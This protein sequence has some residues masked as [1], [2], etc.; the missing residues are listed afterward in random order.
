MIVTSALDVVVLAAARTPVTGRSRAQ[1]HRTAYQLAADVIAPLAVDARAHLG[2]EPTGV[3]LG[4]CIGPGGNIARVAALGAGLDQRVTGITVDAQC[5]SGLVAIIQAAGQSQLVGA[6]LIAGGTESPSTAPIRTFR[7][8]SYDQ[9]PFTPSGWPDPSMTE[10]ADDLATARGISR[11]RQEDAALRSHA[12]SLRHAALAT[13]EIAETHDGLSLGR[14]DGPR[15]LDSTR[16]ARFSPVRDSPRAT[17][18]PTTAA[19]IADGAAAVLLAPMGGGLHEVAGGAPTSN[20][21]ILPACRI[22]A[23]A[24]VGADPQQPGIVAANAISACLAAAG[25]RLQQLSAV[26]I[27]EAYAAQLLAVVDEL[28]LTT[29]G[30]TETGAPPQLDPRVNA[31]G[32]ALAL[33][34]PWG[35]S[36]A[37][38]LGRLVRRLAAAEPGALG[39]AACAIAGGMGSAVIVE[40]LEDPRGD[41]G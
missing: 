17:V 14:D 40:R 21:T 25:V 26:E 20:R 39:V 31:A 12:L 16:A 9:A 18:T 15:R 11:A 24:L 33:G 1:S 36:G 35:A 7:G 41:Q 5:G 2:V 37:I 3:V 30:T 22:R 8:V 34:H 28:G 27:V 23:T 4:N 29:A 32:G 38:A 6:P 19:R 13:T 10:A